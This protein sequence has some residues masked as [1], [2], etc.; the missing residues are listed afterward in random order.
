[1][2]KKPMAKGFSGRRV[3]TGAHL[4]AGLVGRSFDL[5]GHAFE[6]L[7]VRRVLPGLVASQEFR[8]DRIGFLLPGAGIARPPGDAL[9]MVDKFMDQDG[10]AK[11]IADVKIRPVVERGFG[12]D[13]ISRDVAIKHFGRH[14][15]RRETD[16]K[17]RRGQLGIWRIGSDPR[18]R[19]LDR[20]R[21][22]IVLSLA[23]HRPKAEHG[24]KEKAERP[25][26]EH[27]AFRD[28]RGI[29]FRAASVRNRP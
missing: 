3:S 13:I 21:P 20:R 29:R 27:P 22:G 17:A 18:N 1:M 10:C 4:I 9:P 19:V 11:E 25:Y 12:A 5:D 8:L 7:G 6:A 16:P 28:H 14:V 2:R 23:Q 24:E 15:V 26:G